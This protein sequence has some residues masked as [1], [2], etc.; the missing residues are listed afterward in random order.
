[1]DNCFKKNS[2]QE[3][4]KKYFKSLQNSLIHL[5]TLMKCTTFWKIIQFQN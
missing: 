3:M 1:M 5:E 2:Y 4:I